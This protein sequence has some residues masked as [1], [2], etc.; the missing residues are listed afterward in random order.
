MPLLDLGGGLGIAYTAD[1][2]PVAIGTVAGQL[3]EIVRRGVR[4][5]RVSACRGSRSSRAGRSPVRATVTLYEV[6]TVKDVDGLRTYV[7][8]DGGMS[9]NIRT[10]LYDADYTCALAS[11]ASDAPPCWPG[12]SESTARAGDIVVRDTW[13]PADVAPGDLLAVAATGAYCRA[14]RAT[15]TTCPGRRWSRCATARPG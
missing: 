12:W 8:V 11:G 13:L 6:G 14:W 1:D 10:A 5:R 15:T 7:S 4:G 2:D 9:D 3:A